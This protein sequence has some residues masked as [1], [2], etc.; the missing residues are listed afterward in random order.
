MKKEIEN[1]FTWYANKVAETV[2]YESWTDE[3][4]RKEVKESTEKFLA[5]LNK[6][7]DWNNLTEEDCRDLRFGKWESD[8]D[9]D[10]EIA[11]LKNPEKEH[12]LH[13]GETVE[14]AIEKLENTRGIMLLPLYILPIVPIGTELTSIGGDTVI[15]DGKNVN[16]D[17]R[18]GCIAYGIKLKGASK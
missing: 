8:E 18:F 11:D 15:F 2:Q 7:I 14:Q 6:Y 4:A 1:C 5:E 3:F 16:K 9:I 17:I 10:A 13:D 12:Y